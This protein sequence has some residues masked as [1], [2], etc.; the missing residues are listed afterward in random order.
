MYSEDTPPKWMTESDKEALFRAG[1]KYMDITD[2][3]NPP[4]SS[5][6]AWTPCKSSL[7]H[8]VS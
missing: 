3:P 7:S 2:F 6:T 8:R 1:V 5:L 4:V